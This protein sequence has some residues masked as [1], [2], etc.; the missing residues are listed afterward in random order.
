MRGQYA[1]AME[2]ATPEQFWVDKTTCR[3]L[4]ENGQIKNPAQ[5]DCAQGI[6]AVKAIAIA[7]SQGQKIYTI[8]QGNRATALPKLTIGGD[9]GAEIRNAINAGKEV[10]F[11]ESPINAHGWSGYGY[12][13]TDPDTGAGAYVI[14]GKGN[15]GWLSL[16]E[17]WSALLQLV[18]LL[19]GAV[20]FASSIILGI[21]DLIKNGLSML[22][23]GCSGSIIVQYALVM[24]ILTL[25]FALM[26]PI[27]APFL[28][29]LMVAIFAAMVSKQIYLAFGGKCKA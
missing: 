2:H 18:N 3:Y 17:M 1:S 13:I 16:E 21:I 26:A 9:V 22:I 12:I 29:S 14:E 15:G 10:T 7:Q 5:A 28:L 27:G 6:S 19:V 23:D 8:N 4:D 20:D 11:H 24:A 25:G